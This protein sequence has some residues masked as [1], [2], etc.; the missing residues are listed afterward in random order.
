MD[1]Y[2]IPPQPNTSLVSR[3]EWMKFYFQERTKSLYNEFEIYKAPK[4]E[5]EVV[6]MTGYKTKQRNLETAQMRKERRKRESIEKLGGI[7][8]DDLPK[9]LDLLCGKP[10]RIT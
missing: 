8:V 9:D 2:S 4:V 7:R 1:K 10:R 3:E 6:K 5:R